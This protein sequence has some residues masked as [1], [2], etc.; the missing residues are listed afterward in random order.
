MQKGKSQLKRTA[1]SIVEI[2]IKERPGA[3]LPL[4]ILLDGDISFFALA[5]LRNLLF[6]GKSP[7]T[8]L[9]TA[10]AIGLFYDYYTLEKKAV[11]L[12]DERLRLVLMQFYEARRFGCPSLGWRARK[13]N[14]V[15]DE[16]RY[17]S[18]FSLFC[19]EN[20]G[21]ACVNPREEQFLQAFADVNPLR[22][23]ARGHAR[24]AYDLLYHLYPST[25]EARG[26]GK[27]WRFT[28]EAN[29]RPVGQISVKHFPVD[30]VLD[31]IVQTPSLR[32][33]LCWLLM[34][35]GGLR[36]SELLHIYMT[37]ITLSP[38]ET[39]RV[40]LS[41]PRDATYDWTGTDGKRKRGSRSQF[42]SERYSMS[43]RNLLGETHPLRAGW[44]SMLYDD[45]TQMEAEV[46]WIDN[47]IGKIFWKMHCEY[48]R[49]LRFHVP[50]RHPFY[51]VNISGADFGAP[52]KLSN[53]EK[54]F[55][56]GAGRVG[57]RTSL[58]GVN[59]QGARH[60]YGYYCANF[61]RLP[62]ERVQRML[63][64][65]SALST[66]VYYNLDPAVIRQEL[67]KA[68]SKIKD[69]LPTFLN[70]DNAFMLRND[71]NA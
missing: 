13:G 67:S 11:P 18:G 31:F 49:S 14:T 43:S 8:V 5:Y 62:K 66:E 24:K 36:I 25:K 32:D 9:R 60:F 2:P 61:L 35:F 44:K 68:Q 29:G 1:H 71:H 40:V 65:K 57:L 7:S 30:R 34:F 69:R 27:S 20:F 58:E 19:A 46:Y 54:R 41:D 45:R 52:L 23:A 64:H 39:A 42:L 56:R 47:C 55:A 6:F 3:S 10:K 50:D 33:R 16:V 15:A 70:A 4:L 17:V 38:D 48:M 28:P 12:S 37:D 22:Q 26:T 63:H 51:F 53:L 21:H 59:P